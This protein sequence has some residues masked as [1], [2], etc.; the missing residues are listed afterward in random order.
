MT[1]E[2]DASNSVVCLLYRCQFTLTFR[3]SG[4]LFAKLWVCK[5]DR[6]AIVSFMMQRHISYRYSTAIHYRM[7]IDLRVVFCSWNFHDV[8]SSDTESR[9]QVHSAR[10]YESK[11]R[12]NYCGKCNGR[13]SEAQKKEETRESTGC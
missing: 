1:G 11:K 5:Y 10:C 6:M 9:V 2:C 3:E 12:G 8:R 4:K 7:G 13:Y